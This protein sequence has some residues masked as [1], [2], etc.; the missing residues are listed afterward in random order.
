MNSGLYLIG[1]EVILYDKKEL[2]QKF[3]KEN[4]PKMINGQSVQT[5]FAQ[6]WDAEKEQAYQHLCAEEK[7]KPEAMQQVLE[8]YEFTQRLPHKEGLKDLPNFKVKLFER[9][10]VLSNLLLKTRKLIEKFY[11]GF[12]KQP[13]MCSGTEGDHV[14]AVDHDRDVF[15][16]MYLI[17]GITVCIC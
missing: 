11:V 4:M 13:V 5:A 2:I 6:C 12:K 8:H 16:F 14:T 3:I 10:N 1:N 9:E 7:L 17:E 15:W